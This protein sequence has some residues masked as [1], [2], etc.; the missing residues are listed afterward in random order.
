VLLTVF[1]PS[2]TAGP[3]VVDNPVVFT[4][5]NRNTSKVPC[6]SDGKTYRV[7]GRMVAPA[8]IANDG[9]QRAVTVYVHGSGGGQYW[10][11][12]AV[13]GYDYVTELARLGHASISLDNLGYGQSDIPDGNAVC[14]GSQADVL[15]QVVDDLRAGTYDDGDADRAAPA[16]TKV[17]IVGHSLGGDL[18]ETVASSFHD[19]DA[20]VV[21]EWAGEGYPALLAQPATR[22]GI[23]CATGGEPKRP[24]A[25]G[26]YAFIF[27]SADFH[28]A[29]LFNTDPAVID[30]RAGAYERDFC[31]LGPSAAQNIIINHA[32]VAT[33]NVPVLLAYGDP[34]AGFAPGTPEEEKAQYLASPDVRVAVIADCGHELMNC[35]AA[36]AF[37]AAMDQ[38]LTAR[39][40]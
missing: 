34:G 9:R 2:A 30:A 26:G 3:D 10:H 40:F 1:V 32:L 17:A 12:Q 29:F 25:A 31:G 7:R 28:S 23:T 27:N 33:I 20:L 14:V 13:P 5:I 8:Q 4:V 37:R 11:F 22:F 36:P 19:V 39:G 16:F 21:A 35:R 38:W 15:H 24:G 6:Q 18:A